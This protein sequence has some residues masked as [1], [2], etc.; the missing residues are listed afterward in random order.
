MRTNSQPKQGVINMWYTN[1]YE[2]I[3]VYQTYVGTSVKLGCATRSL[4][5]SSSPKT[6]GVP[7]K[8]QRERDQDPSPL[9]KQNNRMYFF[10]LLSTQGLDI[11]IKH[12][13]LPFECQFVFI[14]STHII[15]HCIHYTISYAILF[16]FI[17]S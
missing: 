15:I 9:R 8:N 5:A 6:E 4:Y 10:T 11:N 13:H 2:N 12:I 1:I 14:N 3:I 16:H 7:T 17:D